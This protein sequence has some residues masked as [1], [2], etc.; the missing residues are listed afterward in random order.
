M[1]IAWDCQPDLPTLISD[2][3]KLKH[4]MQN[5]I[6]NALKFTDEGYIR[7]RSSACGAKK[8]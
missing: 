5:L 3:N 7:V 2:T 1:T 8:K 6:N 4:I